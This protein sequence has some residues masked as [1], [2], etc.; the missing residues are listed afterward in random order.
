MADDYRK[1]GYHVVYTAEPFSA[2]AIQEVDDLLAGKVSVIMGQ[3]GAGKSTLLN[4]VAPDLKLETGEISAS[5]HRG[6]HT[7]RR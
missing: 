3:T 1:I 6:K 5:L 7:T 2:A 4:H